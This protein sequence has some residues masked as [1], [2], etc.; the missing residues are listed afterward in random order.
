M[1][2]LIEMSNNDGLVGRCDAKCY[3]ASKPECN[4]ICGGKNHGVGKGQALENT[5]RIAEE[6]IA[7]M[8]GDNKLS[9]LAQQ[10]DLL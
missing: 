4:C 7:N 10:L 5:K 6:Q 1:T 2:T 3:N 9:F 8:N